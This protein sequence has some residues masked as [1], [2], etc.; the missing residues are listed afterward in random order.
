MIEIRACLLFMLD[1]LL[2]NNYA[3]P[4]V[5]LYHDGIA[6]Y[7]DFSH[8]SDEA[9]ANSRY[10]LHVLMTTLIFAQGLTHEKDVLREVRLLDK[11]I[12]PK[13]LH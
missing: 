6:I 1:N 12:R 2:L 3:F 8:G 13:S 7:E 11:T 4:T 10:C 5:A 9:I